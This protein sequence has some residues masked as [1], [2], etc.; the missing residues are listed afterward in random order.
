MTLD[1]ISSLE[2]EI[3]RLEQTVQSQSVELED[4]RA[5]VAE[6]RRKNQQLEKELQMVTEESQSIISEWNIERQKIMTENQRL[7]SVCA[8]RLTEIE[9][10][11]Y[12][13]SRLLIKLSLSYAELERISNKI[14]GKK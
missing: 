4:L 1:K 5:V 11:S 9:D 12:E 14:E 10:K 6:L 7:Q 2:F 3:R 8:D 13:N